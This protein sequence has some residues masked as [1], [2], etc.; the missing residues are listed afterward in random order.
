LTS[1]IFS[2]DGAIHA[3]DTAPDEN[4]VALVGGD[5][6]NLLYP[7]ANPKYSNNYG[8]Y[9]MLIK[10]LRLALLDYEQFTTGPAVGIIRGCTS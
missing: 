10:D 2:I 3:C 4:D 1:Y 5:V 6:M 8:F 7:N 9:H